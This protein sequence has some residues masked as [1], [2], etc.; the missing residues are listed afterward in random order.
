MITDEY[1]WSASNHSDLPDEANGYCDTLKD[2]FTAAI[3]YLREHE[4]K[5]VYVNHTQYDDEQCIA[6]KIYECN[7]YEDRWIDM[8]TQERITIQELSK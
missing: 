6:E 3:N 2:A 1:S 4:P 5:Y 7:G 8:D